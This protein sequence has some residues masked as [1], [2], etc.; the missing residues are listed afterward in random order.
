MNTSL[1]G[2]PLM[3]VSEFAKTVGA[4]RSQLIFYD[5]MGVFSP[6]VR[7][8]QG[9]HASYR[10]YTADQIY[11]YNMLTFYQKAGYSLSEAGRLC[12]REI[13]EDDTELTGGLERLKRQQER[14]M[15]TIDSIQLMLKFE[16]TTAGSTASN[17]AKIELD[18]PVSCLYCK[19]DSE[20]RRGTKSFAEQYTRYIA[21]INETAGILPFPIGLIYHPDADESGYFPVRGV[22][23]MFKRGISSPKANFTLPA[24]KYIAISMKNRLHNFSAECMPLREYLKSNSLIRTTPLIGWN[25]SVRNENGHIYYTECLSIS[26]ISGTTPEGQL[27]VLPDVY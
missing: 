15:T 6:M 17:P 1:H 3:S 20:C 26:V 22:I 19:F 14:I 8:A 5:K 27:P 21:E 18:K 25:M 4:T 7:T 13:A 2:E 11:T 24:G 10:F 16:K 23:A 9:T 12:Q